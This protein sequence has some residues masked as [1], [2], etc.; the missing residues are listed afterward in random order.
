[1]NDYLIDRR[2]EAGV[3]RP[4]NAHIRVILFFNGLPP[5]NARL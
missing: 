1:V 4:F 5:G 3:A 2:L